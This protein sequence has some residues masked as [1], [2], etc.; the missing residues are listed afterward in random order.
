VLMDDIGIRRVNLQ[1]LK[2]TAVTDVISFRYA[3]SP[4]HPGICDGEIVVNVQRAVDVGPA[5][6]GIA[7]ELALYAA[8]GCDHLSGADDRTAAERARM[9]RRELRWLA[10]A[11]KLGLLQGLV[12]RPIPSGNKKKRRVSR[13]RTGRACRRPS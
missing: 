6:G 2:R 13:S 12:S 8:H 4:E 7:R 1:C 5:Y 3:P 11:G 10:E 9:R